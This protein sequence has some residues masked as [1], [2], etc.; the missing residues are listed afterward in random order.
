MKTTSWLVRGPPKWC[1]TASS[2][3]PDLSAD[4]RLSRERGSDLRIAFPRGTSCP[5]SFRERLAGASQDPAGSRGAASPSTLHLAAWARGGRRPLE[6][7]VLNERHPESNGLG[8]Q[9][10]LGNAS[11]TPTTGPLLTRGCVAS[12]GSQAKPSGQW[13]QVLGGPCGSRPI[14]GSQWSQPGQWVQDTVP[15]VQGG[16]T[17]SLCPAPRGSQYGFFLYSLFPPQDGWGSHT[18]LFLVRNWVELLKFQSH[19][20]TAILERAKR[21]KRRWARAPPRAAPSP[22]GTS[23]PTPQPCHP[24]SSNRSCPSTCQP[25]RLGALPAPGLPLPCCLWTGP[26]AESRSWV[27]A[28]GVCQWAGPAT[29]LSRVPDHGPASCPAVLGG[30]GQFLRPQPGRPPG[31]PCGGDGS[32]AGGQL[33]GHFCLGLG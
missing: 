27:P 12:A 1:F 15:S 14:S 24:S 6:G 29:G 8:H 23:C 16:G 26:V 9:G 10:R 28:V 21:G 2:S 13:P 3:A 7:T 4:S 31:A 30:G 20:L 33:C 11:S 32:L 19:D 22:R 17:R 25:C 18:C 5:G